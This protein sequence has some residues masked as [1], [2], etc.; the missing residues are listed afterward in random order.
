MRHGDDFPYTKGMK[1][2][3]RKRLDRKHETLSSQA[4]DEAGVLVHQ[5]NLD[6]LFELLRRDLDL[7]YRDVAV[8]RRLR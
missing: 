5:W 1:D 2:L 4:N 7:V 3:R 6:G 8:S